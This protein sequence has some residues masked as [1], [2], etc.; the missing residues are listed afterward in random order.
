MA[1]KN[2]DGNAGSQNTSGSGAS[3]NGGAGVD[4]SAGS[5]TGTGTGSGAT[6]T[7]PFENPVEVSI[8]A[9]VPI[10]GDNGKG[11]ENG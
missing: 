10:K 5:G 2:D 9:E 7:N 3:S 8:R 4:D 1:E 6:T 11:S